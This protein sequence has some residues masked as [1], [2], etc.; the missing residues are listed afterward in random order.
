MLKEPSKEQ[1]SHLPDQHQTASTPL[2]QS[3]TTSKNTSGTPPVQESAR[4]TNDQRFQLEPKF[5][6]L[7][8]LN[9]TLAKAPVA[10][11]LRLLSKRKYGFTKPQVGTISAFC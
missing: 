7:T 2:P 11:E 3:K 6:I 1:Q 5:P 4:A 8:R 9:K 10:A